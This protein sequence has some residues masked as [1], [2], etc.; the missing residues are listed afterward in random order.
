MVTAR[1][2]RERV[3]QIQK[4]S[5]EYKAAQAAAAMSF[6]V[7]PDLIVRPGYIP[8]SIGSIPT[9][10]PPPDT[11]QSGGVSG[12][13]SSNTGGYGPGVQPVPGTGGGGTSGGSSSGGS[14]SSGGGTTVSTPTTS[15]STPIS[16]PSGGGLGTVKTGVDTSVYDQHIQ[17]DIAAS[18]T[19]PGEP[20]T[21]EAVGFLRAAGYNISAPDANNMVSIVP[22][23]SYNQYIMYT[24]SV[25][26]GTSFVSTGGVTTVSYPMQSNVSPVRTLRRLGQFEGRVPGLA[27]IAESV[28]GIM[29][30]MSGVSRPVSDVFGMTPNKYGVRPI[31]MS[32]PNVVYHPL[33]MGLTPGTPEYNNALRNYEIA[34]AS[35][36]KPMTAENKPV[37]P[38]DVFNLGVGLL[39]LPFYGGALSGLG[40]ALPVAST[41]SKV[42][43][44]GMTVATGLFVAGGVKQIVTEPSPMRKVF[45]SVSLAAMLGVGIKSSGMRMSDIF[46]GKKTEVTMYKDIPFGSNVEG[47]KIQSYYDVLGLKVK[48]GEPL[49][50]V[51]T[52]AIRSSEGDPDL[53]ISKL[54]DR[55]AIGS[56]YSLDVGL[57]EPMQI[58]TGVLFEKPSTGWG[59]FYLQL[60]K[61]GITKVDVKAK[62]SSF[63]GYSTGEYLGENQGLFVSGS[64]SVVVGKKGNIAFEKSITISKTKYPDES[65]IK[66]G[67]LGSFLDTTGGTTKRGLSFD[68]V[69]NEF[70]YKS[71]KKLEIETSVTKGIVKS[72]KKSEII[73]GNSKIVTPGL[74]V[75][76]YFGEQTIGG[77]ALEEKKSLQDGLILPG[78]IFGDTL[79]RNILNT[80]KRSKLN[81]MSLPFGGIRSG[82]YDEQPIYVSDYWI[83]QGSMPRIRQEKISINDAIQDFSFKQGT[84]QVSIQQGIGIQDVMQGTINISETGK[85]NV[86]RQSQSQMQRQIQLQ[87]QVQVQTQMQEQSNIQR[88]VLNFAFGQ[89]SLSSGKSI[90]K[91][92]LLGEPAFNVQVKGRVYSQGKRIAGD[93]WH[94]A[95]K[96]LLSYNDALSVGADIVGKNEK[97]SFRVIPVDGKPQA[98][99]RRVKP[100]YEVAYQ[101]NKRNG[102]TY[103]EKPAYRINSPGE[104]MAITMKG[105]QANRRR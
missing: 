31:D 82:G 94:N 44:G 20:I 68:A 76:D 71:G 49:V 62:T 45:E 26:S 83:K 28:K 27:P 89:G 101:F 65:I 18:G 53:F 60:D 4:K 35:G 7:N 97:A 36:A 34:K 100:F 25:P 38:S 16:T 37:M 57:K 33:V 95:S 13:G 12:G 24:G 93:N 55:Y 81:T 92:E 10:T 21:P 73:I 102:D 84:S 99:G 66:K 86:Q 63:T 19:R 46:R 91:T 5:R 1:Q 2:L 50:G 48:T 22:P 54:N 9:P 30:W 29:D 90:L 39:Q 103:V 87:K 70:I 58:S 41:V 69:K 74:D 67:E 78:G 15:T 56:A 14:R 52:R 80:I 11:S 104:L 40:K 6:S 8:P 23:E 79:S 43:S 3:S 85:L 32:Q 77:S 64:K 88:L 61:V 59:S 42:Y 17:S 105:I 47:V 98:I 72:G 51:R 75:K 96:K